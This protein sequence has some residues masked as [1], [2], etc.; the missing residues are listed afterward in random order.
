MTTPRIR[1]RVFIDA[2]VLF[3]GAAS[4]SEHGASLVVLRL[5]EVTLIDALSSV[6][7]VTEAERSLTDKLPATVPALRLI[8]SRSLTVVPD[9]APADL[10]PFTGWAD[11]KDLPILVAAMREEC[12]HLVTFNVRHFTP[13]DDRIAVVAPGELTRRVRERLAMLD[14]RA[15][16]AS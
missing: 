6:Q 15:E 5:A 7:A 1:P 2:D 3:A 16:S 12:A 8:V 10:A 4:P 11:R 14:D 9:P 13:R